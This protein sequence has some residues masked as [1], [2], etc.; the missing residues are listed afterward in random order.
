MTAG[1]FYEEKPPI[2]RDGPRFHALW[3][4]GVIF[5]DRERGDDEDRYRQW[6]DIFMQTATLL[7]I[8]GPF[9]HASS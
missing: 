7:Y 9:G 5:S 6:S 4:Y 2:L 3:E 8:M 1:I